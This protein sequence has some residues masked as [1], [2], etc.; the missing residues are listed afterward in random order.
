MIELLVAI[1]LLGVAIALVGPFTVKQ[2]DSA[3]ARNEQLQLQRWIQKQSSNAFTSESPIFLR[4]DGKA[5][6]RTLLPGSSL[7]NQEVLGQGSEV[8]GYA[9]DS[10][11]YGTGYG[12][13]YVADDNNGRP[14]FA[15]FEEFL[16]YQEGANTGS[17]V[18]VPPTLLFN[19][20]F[21]EPQTL[22]VNSHGYIDVQFIEYNY[23]GVHRIIDIN[24]LLAGGEK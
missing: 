2:V 1:V 14:A 4:F 6:F 9:T 15:N 21:F 16:N 24:Q 22:T 18:T 7:Y 13:Q 17:H 3:K 19:H 12:V 8:E 11:D 23:R 10:A 20:L 5:V